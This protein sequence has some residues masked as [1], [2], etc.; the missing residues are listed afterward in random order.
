V[1]LEAVPLQHT[2][3]GLGAGALD[4]RQQQ[5]GGFVA[6]ARESAQLTTT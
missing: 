4:S 2:G 5:L 6:L 1:P 3:G